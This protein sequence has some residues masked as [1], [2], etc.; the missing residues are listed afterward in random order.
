MS[1][2]QTYDFIVVGGGPAGCTLASRLAQLAGKPSVLL[3][4]AGGR[5]DDRSLRVDGT[6]HVVEYNKYACP[7]AGDHG[8]KGVLGIGYAKEWEQDLPLVLDALEQ[9]GFPRNNDHNSGNPI[10]M[11]LS[12]NSAREGL[13]TTVTDLLAAAPANLVTITESP[14]QRVI[15]EGKKAVG[16]ESNGNQLFNIPVV[17]DLPAVGQGLRDHLFVPV[18]V[19]R[20]PE[21]N[22]RNSFFKHQAAM[23]SAMKQWE[24]DNTGQWARYL[25]LAMMLMNEQSVGEVRLQSSNPDDPL[26]FDPK[27]LEHSFDRRACIEI[28]KHL[29]EVMNHPSFAKDTVST[30]QGPSSESDEDI[31]EFWR[32]NLSSTWHMT[33]TAK[34]ATAYVTSATAADVLIRDYGLDEKAR[35]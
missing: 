6:I 30:I 31:L 33:G 21:T 27:F 34:M 25:S 7:A 26:L 14:V 9:A 10:G 2:E 11:A 20:N 19:T 32:N 22:D 17:H 29:M 18:A 4:E 13:R 15:M 12:I 1:S 5:N 8:T 23:A 3:L 35:V 28:Y 24:T 16:V